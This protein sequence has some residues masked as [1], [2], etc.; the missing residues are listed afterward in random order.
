MPPAIA[1]APEAFRLGPGPSPEAVACALQAQGAPGLAWL[2]GSGW[3]RDLLTAWPAGKRVSRP[4]QGDPLPALEALLG[5]GLVL[6]AAGYDL[7][8]RMDRFPR[9]A[10]DDLGEP[11]LEAVLYPGALLHDGKAWWSLGDPPVDLLKV[12]LTAR[13][14]GEPA[15]SPA[16]GAL[17]RNFSHEGFR[18]AVAEI[19]RLIFD[20]EIYQANLAQRF[21]MA[22][23]ENPLG[24]YRRLRRIAAAPY[25]AFLD[26]GQGALLSASPELFLEVTGRRVL[27]RPIKGTRPRGRTSEEDAGLVA[28]LEASRKD[29]AELAMI[30]D[31]ERNDLGRVCVPGSIRVEVPR[32]LMSIPTVHHAWA[33]VSGTLREGKGLVDLLKA[34]FPGGSVTG[35]PRIRAMEVI[36][37]LEPTRRGIYCG[38]VGWAYGGDCRLNLAIRTL[39]VAEGRATLHAGAGIVAD[40]D[41]QAEYLETLDKARGMLEALGAARL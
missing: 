26:W 3:G 6:L 27:T 39:S 37:S 36:D 33:E 31:L 38:A 34:A 12:L 9:R 19:L 25:G 10:L 15:P 29:R 13:D 1:R 30:V 14:P 8:G 32:R 41:P 40:S 24:I 5:R 20:G 35:C 7:G 28:E 23:A 17:E 4:S 22:V 11:E 18:A 21:R 16:P 2:D